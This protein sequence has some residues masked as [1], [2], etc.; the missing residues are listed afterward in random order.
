MAPS[1]AASAAGTVD[2]LTYAPRSAAA[3][4]RASRRRPSPR[5]LPVGAGSGSSSREGRHGMASWP[6]SPRRIA[7]S[8]PTGTSTRTRSAP[9]RTSSVASLVASKALG[10]RSVVPIQGG[11]RSPRTPSSSWRAVRLAS[12]RSI[13]A[14][15]SRLRRASACSR[16]S[17]AAR[18]S[19]SI[20]RSTAPP[21][22]SMA[23]CCGPTSYSWSAMANG[24]ATPEARRSSRPSTYRSTTSAASG[25]PS[26]SIP[27]TPMSRRIARSRPSVRRLDAAVPRSAASAVA[28]SR[29]RSSS[30]ANCPGASV[31]AID[32][33]YGTGPAA[34]AAPGGPCQAVLAR[35]SLPPVARESSR[36]PE[37]VVRPVR[38]RGGG[39]SRA[40]SPIQTCPPANR[41]AFQIGARAFV[42][43]IA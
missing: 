15:M 33:G 17:G 14:S 35:L 23:S 38:Q 25:R 28:R 26:R 31:G 40:G 20:A 30:A 42:S 37:M 2:S 16:C 22:T 27:P 13:A 1:G 19:A 39:P 36:V 24:S 11:S 4:S 43:S 10:S 34:L 21:E 7:S 12:I 9:A 41:S 32:R 6:S 29:R 8:R 18:S 5:W 3:R